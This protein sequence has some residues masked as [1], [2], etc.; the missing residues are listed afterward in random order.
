[1][2]IFQF[3]VIIL[4]IIYSGCKEKSSKS[5]LEIENKFIDLGEVPI[6]KEVFGSIILKNTGNMDVKVL[7]TFSDC[8][9]TVLDHDIGSIGPKESK[10]LGF[11]FTSHYPGIFQRKIIIETNSEAKPKILVIMKAKVL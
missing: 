7:S 9:C 3:I 11:S 5:V 6:G 4:V 2:R 1:M 8:E 10:I